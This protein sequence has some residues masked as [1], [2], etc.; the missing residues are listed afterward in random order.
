[1]TRVVPR[2]RDAL[3]GSHILA[4]LFLPSGSLRRRR[5]GSDWLTSLWKG[6]GHSVAGLRWLVVSWCVREVV[7]MDE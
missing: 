1:M 5:V 2:I 3:S 4:L 6:E 7:V